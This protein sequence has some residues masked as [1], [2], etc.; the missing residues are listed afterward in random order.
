M[1]F[2]LRYAADINVPGIHGDV[3]QIVQ[4]AEDADVAE[5][6]HAR[7]ETETDAGIQRLEHRE[8]SFQGFL[9]RIV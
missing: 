5:L 6:A 1:Q 9:V 7:D 3:I 8:E 2:F 4:V